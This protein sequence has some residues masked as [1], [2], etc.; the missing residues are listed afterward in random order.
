[1]ELCKLSEGR[2][3]ASGSYFV[4]AIRR[5]KFRGNFCPFSVS[6]FTVFVILIAINVTTLFFFDLLYSNH[7]LSI[8]L[9]ERLLRKS[10]G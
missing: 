3:Y 5:G 7:V 10:L 1:M 2:I 8:F 6:V 4:W 9:L